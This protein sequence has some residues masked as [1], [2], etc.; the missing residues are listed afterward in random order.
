MEA[1]PS[2]LASLGSEQAHPPG[3]I[4]H[5][6]Y[7]ICLLREWNRQVKE[8]SEKEFPRTG[9]TRSLHEEMGRR[10][11]D[12]ALPPESGV[13][14]LLPMDLYPLDML[15]YRVRKAAAERRE[16]M[17]RQSEEMARRQQM[18]SLAPPQ[19]MALPRRPAAGAK[20]RSTTTTRNK[21]A[22]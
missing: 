8:G 21:G 10:A 7:Q 3:P 16:R 19:T 22:L 18:Q 15:D 4:R 6:L 11:A 2:L 14:S 13:D 1:V 9:W 5:R 20:K 12:L 17:R